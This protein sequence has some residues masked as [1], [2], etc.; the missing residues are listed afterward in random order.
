VRAL[1]NLTA[2][3]ATNLHDYHRTAERPVLPD[4]QQDAG[5]PAAR[6]IAPW[7]DEDQV[8]ADELLGLLRPYPAELIRDYPVEHRVG[9]DTPTSI[10]TLDNDLV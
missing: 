2:A 3:R 5:H 7:L 9:N 1:E 4:S 8:D 6:S 10:I